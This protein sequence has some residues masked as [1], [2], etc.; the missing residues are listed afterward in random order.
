MIRESKEQANVDKAVRESKEAAERNLMNKVME[1]SLGEQGGE[2]RT[3][4]E[5][6]RKGR[7][8]NHGG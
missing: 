2:D 8:R 3:E 6:T 4:E 1:K 7:G 5:V